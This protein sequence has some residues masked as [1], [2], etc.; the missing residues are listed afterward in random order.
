MRQF[1]FCTAGLEDTFERMINHSIDQNLQEWNYLEIGLG[2][3]ETLAAVAAIMNEREVKPKTWRIIGCDIKVKPNVFNHEIWKKVPIYMVNETTFALFDNIVTA[4]QI[5][6]KRLP[7]YVAPI[8]FNYVFIDGCHEKE[9]VK[10]DFTGIEPHV[11]KDG[12]VVMHDYDEWIE[13][14][15]PQTFHNGENCAVMAAVDDLGLD[16]SNVT[17]PGWSL[18]NRLRANN[19][20][21]GLDALALRK[22]E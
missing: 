8:K 19:A 4:V 17:R 18:I 21:L 1:G 13:G 10:T 16:P 20:L 22:Y 6:S 5:D 7:V 3:G 14:G 11:A 12:V 2:Y 9:C 15:D